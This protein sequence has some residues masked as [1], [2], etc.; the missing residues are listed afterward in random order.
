MSVVGRVWIRLSVYLLAL[1][2]VATSSA[3]PAQAGQELHFRRELTLS[4][5]GLQ[6]LDAFGAYWFFD[7]GKVLLDVDAW[8]GDH[9]NCFVSLAAAGSGSGL[10]YKLGT[11][12]GFSFLV[13]DAADCHID[14]VD[15]VLRASARFDF[16]LLGAGGGTLPSEMRVAITPSGVSISG[17][18]LGI[19]D[20]E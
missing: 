15:G 17:F 12:G 16:D 18:T 1:G 4:E 11:S 2:V 3:R 13:F 5:A 19:E 20:D 6:T 7:R 8:I 14:P 9:G 10:N